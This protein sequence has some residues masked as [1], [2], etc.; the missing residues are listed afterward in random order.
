MFKLELAF[1][2][3]GSLS[4]QHPQGNHH[5]DGI[6]GPLLDDGSGLPLQDAGIGDF[7]Q[8]LDLH[9]LL[10]VHF[11]FESSRSTTFGMFH[12]PCR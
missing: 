8:G 11:E 10:I 9:N 5:D 2:P 3:D 4:A 6:G 12:S 1:F 7:G